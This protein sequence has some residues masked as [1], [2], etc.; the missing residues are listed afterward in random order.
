MDGAEDAA[1]RSDVAPA[2]EIEER[3]SR[4]KELSFW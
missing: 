1:S 3:V 2:D 4:L